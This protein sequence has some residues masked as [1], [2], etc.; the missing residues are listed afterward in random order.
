MVLLILKKVFLFN[1]L[2]NKIQKK[3][4]KSNSKKITGVS[5]FTIKHDKMLI[6]KFS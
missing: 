5:D 1:Y 3:I 4:S 6:M 2:I